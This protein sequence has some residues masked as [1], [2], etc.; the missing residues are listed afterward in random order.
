[1]NALVK[2]FSTAERS[3]LSAKA[4]A[5]RKVDTIMSRPYGPSIAE[6]PGFT[7][8]KQQLEAFKSWVFAAV[9]PICNRIAAQPVR[10]G[11]ITG[12]RKL[13][14]KSTDEP[15]PLQTHPIIELLKDPNDLM[16]GWGLMWATVASINLTGRA[17]WWVPEGNENLFLLPASWIKGFEGTTRFQ[18]WRV[19]PEGHGE[20]FDI[21]SE[22]IVYFALPNPSDPWGSISPLQTVAPA[23]N[24]DADIQASQR[25][26]FTRGIH[27]SHAIFVGKQPHPD[28]PGGV[29]PALTNAQQRQIVEAVKRRYAGV[30]NHGEPL[31]L[32]ALIE[33]V[34]RLSN[35]PDEMDW[36][37]S[38][39]QVKDRILQAFGT[40]P[41]ILGGSE[42]GSR[43]AS[44]AAEE[45][46]VASTVNPLIRLMT[47][48]MSEW[49]A[50]MFGDGL[51][52][53]IEPCEAHDA[54]MA[55]RWAETLAK[56]GVITVHELRRLA[57]FGLQEDRAFDGQIVGGK[58]Q[59]TTGLIE[60]GL[61]N[62]V[63]DL[64]AG[65]TA[66]DIVERSKGY[67]L[68]PS[69]MNGRK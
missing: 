6:A 53:W 51:R 58:N 2:A 12:G 66:D 19:Q 5:G 18:S 64:M 8:A 13:G 20:Q 50:P 37:R 59:Q 41:Y 27:P 21:A 30:A 49:M 60:E 48:S 69:G 17:F 11:K 35:T 7:G 61:S 10:V 31:V 26:A 25:Q 67:G 46:F 40:S 39:V 62:L 33:D 38:A 42:P 43:A 22:R 3:Y 45:H 68:F 14:V 56:H 15:E 32:D 44:S 29:R 28:V 65:R 9:R 16:T 47:E 63:S 36:Q 54:D 52:I 4:A 24:N 1:M 23:V 55:L 57:P 34:K